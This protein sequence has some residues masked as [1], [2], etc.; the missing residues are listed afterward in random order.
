MR[1]RGERDAAAALSGTPVAA[2]SG[3]PVAASSGTP[4]AAL[5]G[6]RWRGER[7]RVAWP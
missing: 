3:T 5:S 4:V 1:W 7:W 2:S 6:M